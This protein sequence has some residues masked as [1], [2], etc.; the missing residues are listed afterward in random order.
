MAELPDCMIVK[1]QSENARLRQRLQE[2]I[3]RAEKIAADRDDLRAEIKAERQLNVRSAIAA[4][5][6]CDKFRSDLAA[7]R[8]DAER[9]R[10]GLEIIAGK[11]QC[12]DSLMSN[13]EVA[14]AALQSS[15]K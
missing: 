14:I 8:K 11:R 3:H 5:E 15:S 7:A 9:M 13:A 1:L 4:K 6:L 2:E 12:I 10:E